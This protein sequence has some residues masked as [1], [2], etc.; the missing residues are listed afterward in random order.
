MKNKE[1]IVD[2]YTV[3]GVPMTSLGRMCKELNINEDSL[4]DFLVGQTTGVVGD[5]PM[6]YPWDIKRFING[7]PNLD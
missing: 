5:V 7:L 6:V 4:R 1:Q 2:Q 3:S